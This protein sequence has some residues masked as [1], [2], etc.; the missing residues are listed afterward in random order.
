MNAAVVHSFEAP[1]QYTSFA[2]PV[3]ADGERLVK[4]DHSAGLHPIVKGAGE[5]RSLRQF[6]RAAVCC[7]CGRRREARGW[8]ARLL[9]RRCAK[10][11]WHVFGTCSVAAN[12]GCAS[13]C[14]KV[15]TM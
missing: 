7:W 8:N 1:P 11:V 5:G 6:T 4:R 10:P 12:A 13:R 2:E 9:R 3:A 15:W 14:Q